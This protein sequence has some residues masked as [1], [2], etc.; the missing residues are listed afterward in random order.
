MVLNTHLLIS[1][2]ARELLVMTMPRALGDHRHF[3]NKEYPYKFQSIEQL[4]KDFKNDVER[5]KGVE[6]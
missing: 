4:W 6:L 1:F 3:L 5:V 2:R